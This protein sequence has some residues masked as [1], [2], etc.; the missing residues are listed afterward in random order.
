MASTFTDLAICISDIE[1]PI[2]NVSVFDTMHSVKISSNICGDGLGGSVPA[3]LTMVKQF[4]SPEWC[5]A[6]VRDC[7]PLLLA[8]AKYT[9]RCF[10]DSTTNCAPGN[11]EIV[12]FF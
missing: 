9:P 1:S 2:I 11:N 4:C 8:I 10:K 12:F 7:A 3:A 5:N 6:R